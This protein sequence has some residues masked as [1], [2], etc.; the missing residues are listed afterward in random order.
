MSMFCF[1]AIYSS[2]SLRYVVTSILVTLP[3]TTLK[4]TL[5]PVAEAVTSCLHHHHYFIITWTS[6]YYVTYYCINQAAIFLHFFSRE[7]VFLIVVF[8][9]VASW[10]KKSR[11]CRSCNF[12]HTAANFRQQN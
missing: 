2:C 1:T 10:V 8:I 9:S 4:S 11:V 3:L 6:S 7:F 12:W 5:E